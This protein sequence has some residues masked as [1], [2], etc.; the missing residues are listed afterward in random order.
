MWPVGLLCE[1]HSFLSMT[2]LQCLE[3]NWCDVRSILF[4]FEVITSTHGVF[5][6]STMAQRWGRD[7]KSEMMMNRTVLEQFLFRDVREMG[8]L[9]VIVRTYT[10]K[11]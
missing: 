4:C 5:N 1:H 11:Y 3:L 10:K 7:R 2:K 8:D 6:R 9:L